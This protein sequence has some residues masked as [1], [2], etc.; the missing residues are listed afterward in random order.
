M[1]SSHRR[2]LALAA[3]V[4]T[5]AA[6]GATAFVLPATAPGGGQASAAV[7]SAPMPIVNGTLDWGVLASYRSYVLN[8]AK[9][10]ITPA[11]GAALNADGTFRFTSATGRYDKEG[12]RVVTAAFQGS[13][14]FDAPMHGFKLTLAN[15]R[16]DTG[17]KKLTADVTKN[18]T[19]TPNVPMADV[20]FAGQSM[21]K[22]GTT[23]TKEA[24]DQLGSDKYVGLAGDPLTAALQFGQPSPSP[25]PSA[26]PSPSSSASA[27]PSPTPSG[28]SNSATP[29]QGASSPAAD[30]PQ[31]LLGG[32]LTWGVKEGFRSYVVKGGGSV[33]PADGAVAS[34]DTF[35][36]PLGKGELDVKK[37]KLSATFAG[38][39]R[40]QRADHGIDMTFAHIRVNAEG[41]KGTLVLDVTSPTATKVNVPFATLDLSKAE[42]RISGGLLTLNAVPAAFTAEGAAAIGAPSPDYAEGKP[43]DPVTLSVSV[44]KDVVIPTTAPTTTPTST[45]GGTGGT[46]GT[47][48]GGGSVGGNLA[49]TGAEIPAG[50]LLATSGAV[51]AAG[52]GAV[53]LARRRRAA[54]I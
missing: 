26:T 30:G 16:F 50:A 5:A 15:L 53:F 17:T 12:G 24:A 38:N 34:G 35:A 29:S 42:Y 27:S 49:S 43:T 45:T 31:Q 10:T 20:A 14:T 21:D 44:D 25:S 9:G 7:A 41:K 47:V 11:D 22:L 8:I 18:G 1:S 4:A 51:V 40:F 52:A 23:L 19:L 2:S 28:P 46:G 33:T 37:Q 36:F 6:L 48:G 13:V 3:A 32:R 54:Q 39:L